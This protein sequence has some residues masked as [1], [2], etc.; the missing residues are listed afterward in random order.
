MEADQK[1][2][3]G[4][5]RAYT[6]HLQSCPHRQEKKYNVCTCPKWIYLRP[7]GEKSKRFSL[8]TPSWKE[9]QEI[10]ASTLEGLNPDIA[11]ARKKVAV[12]K[13]KLVTVKGA[14]DLWLDATNSRTERAG[15]R[16]QVAVMVKKF[17]AWAVAEGIEHIQDVTTVQL[18]RWYMGSEWSKYAVLTR[19]QRWIMVRSMFRYWAERG[20]LDKDPIAVIKP[21]RFNGDHVQ[22]P[23]SDEQVVAIQ[24]QVQNDEQLRTFVS[25]LLNTGCDVTDA[26]LHDPLRIE[27]VRIGENTISVYRYQRLKTG[28]EGVIPLSADAAQQLRS[29]KTLP[30]GNANMPFRDPSI[31]LMTDSH[32][33]SKRVKAAINDAGVKWVELPTRDDRGQPKRKPANTK[34]FRHTAA[35]RWLREGQRPEDVGRMLGHVDTLMVRRHYAPWVKELDK[36]HISRVV[37]N[38]AAASQDK[39]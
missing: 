30:K 22:G 16:E 33:W 39:H 38:W 3:Y 1:T 12:R 20:I 13:R 21:V 25:L 23:Y 27:E 18:D 9:A 34:Q 29:I 10:A 19:Q 14:C 36:A 26:V 28:V 2:A 35:V 5:C 15:S 6:R 37:G 8:A 4:S 7:R 11:E 17:M 24:R 31:E 32:A